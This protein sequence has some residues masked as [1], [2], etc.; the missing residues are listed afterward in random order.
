MEIFVGTDIIEVSRIAKLIE[1]DNFVHR[2]FSDAEIRYCEDKVD[3][4]Q[5]YAA[6]FAAKEAVFKALS[7]KLNSNFSVNWNDISIE[8]E[9]NGRP[10]L[11]LYNNVDIS[12]NYRF[13]ISLSHIKDYAIANVVMYSKN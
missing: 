2:I 13:D 11:F 7:S 3:K 4:A 1:N 9:E 6:R 8:K 5:N 12:E 10:V